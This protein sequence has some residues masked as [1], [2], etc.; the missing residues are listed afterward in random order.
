VLDSLIF[1]NFAVAVSGHDQALQLKNVRFIN[2]D[3]PV[4]NGYHFGAGKP[5]SGN[6]GPAAFKTD[7]SPKKK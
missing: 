5:I 3:V 4:E 1:K 6:T 7:S 2:C